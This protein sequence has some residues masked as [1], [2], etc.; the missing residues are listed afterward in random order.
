MRIIRRNEHI[1]MPVRLLRDG[2]L[3]IRAKGMLGVLFTMRDGTVLT[4]Y[5]L[6]AACRVTLEDVLE[7]TQELEKVGYLVREDGIIRLFDAPQND[8]EI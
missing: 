4:E 5:D 6:C 2:E 8:R 1:A 3:S 7:I